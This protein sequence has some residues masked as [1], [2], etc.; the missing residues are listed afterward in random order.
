[1]DFPGL[2]LSMDRL[3]RQDWGDPIIWDEYCY[4]DDRVYQK[5][6]ENSEFLDSSGSKYRIAGIQP[7]ISSWRSLLRFLPNVYKRK[8]IFNKAEGSVTLEEVKLYLLNL[9]NEGENSEAASNFMNHVEQATT[10]RELLAGSTAK[11]RKFEQTTGDNSGH[12][13]SVSRP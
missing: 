13:V 11:T 4:G 10:L 1:M 7:P 12:V 8:L 2:N 5:Y 6:Y 3:P 9:L